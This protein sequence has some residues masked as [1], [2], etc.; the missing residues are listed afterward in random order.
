MTE[1]R[2]HHT[3][4]TFHT[5]RCQ[6]PVPGD[7]EQT[8]QNLFPGLDTHF[9]THCPG[10]GP[11]FRDPDLGQ[12]I[13]EEDFQLRVLTLQDEIYQLPDPLQTDPGG[14]DVLSFQELS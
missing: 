1:C 9:P 8:I 13:G 4:E 7:R 10:H 14:E 6:V 11:E 3:F 12:E 2:L 5:Q